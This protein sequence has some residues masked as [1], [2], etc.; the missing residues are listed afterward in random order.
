MEHWRLGLTLH[1]QF[2]INYF[3][4]RQETSLGTKATLLSFS[5]AWGQEKKSFGWQICIRYLVNVNC[6]LGQC[7]LEP[8]QSLS[9][10]FTPHAFLPME[11]KSASFLLEEEMLLW[12]LM[13]SQG[14][15]NFQRRLSFIHCNLGL[16]EWST[17]QVSSLIWHSIKFTWKCNPFYI[18]KELQIYSEGIVE[19]FFCWIWFEMNVL[20]KYFV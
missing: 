9:L 3:G 19:N 7:W 12:R 16:E 6:T 5:F 20:R 18:F 2:Q 14:S 13:F 11:K 17:L 8:P 10:L 1:F 15:Q 4:H